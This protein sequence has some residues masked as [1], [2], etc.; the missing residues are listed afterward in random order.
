VEWATKYQWDSYDLG[1]FKWC[2]YDVC[3]GI[4]WQFEIL[5]GF[6]G[7]HQFRGFNGYKLTGA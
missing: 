2:G 4:F 5:M 1:G 6:N 3:G 7:S